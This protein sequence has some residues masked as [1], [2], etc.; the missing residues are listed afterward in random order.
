LPIEQKGRL[1]LLDGETKITDEVTLVPTPG[2]SAGHAS[3]V[4]ASGGESAIYIGDIAQK[5][6]QLERTAWVAAFDIMPLVS[7]ETKKRLVEQAIADG[8]LLIAVHAPFPGLGRMT[9]SE[10]GHR[11]WEPVAALPK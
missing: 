5:A 8:S 11:H 1:E 9:R 2:H 6:V 3:V 4:L 7:M 10:Q